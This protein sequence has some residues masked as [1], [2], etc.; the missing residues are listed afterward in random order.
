MIKVLIKQIPVL[1][2]AILQALPEIIVALVEGIVTV[3]I[4][5]LPKIVWE[6]V[7]AL[8]KALSSLGTSLWDLVTGGGG[9]TRRHY[10]GPV[11]AHWGRRAGV[12]EVPALLRDGETVLSPAA[13]RMAQDLN[14][15]RMPRT[16]ADDQRAFWPFLRDFERAQGRSGQVFR[17]RPAWAVGR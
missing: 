2:D 5:A 13:S 10:G 4:P 8:F 1:V 11:V 7:K 16:Y 3:I 9:D 6:L 12:D 14:D 17:T 15:G